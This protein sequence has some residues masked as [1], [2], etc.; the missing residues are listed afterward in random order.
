VPLAPQTLNGSNG[1][2]LKSAA[3]AVLRQEMRL[4]T[5]GDITR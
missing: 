5:T 1:G 2:T 4:M 3:I